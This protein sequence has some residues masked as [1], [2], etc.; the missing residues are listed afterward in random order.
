IGLPL[1][2]MTPLLALVLGLPA[3]IMPVL[4]ASIAIGSVALMLLG[5]M[6]AAIAI[7]ARRASILIA[8]LIL[9]LAMPVLIFGTAAP[10]AVLSGDPAFPHLALLSAA[11]LVLLAITPVATAASLRIAAE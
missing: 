2:V 3:S 11:T 4:T 6:A 7:G 9:P 1:V 5:S 10:L 8:V